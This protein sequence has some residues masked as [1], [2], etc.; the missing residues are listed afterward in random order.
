MTPEASVING[1]LAD[2][3]EFKPTRPEQRSRFLGAETSV[4][5]C[6]L[7]SSFQALQNPRRIADNNALSALPLPMR[8]G[9]SY[10]SP[11]QQLSVVENTG[12]SCTP[13]RGSSL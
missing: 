5:L 7:I 8:Q 12:R 10:P 1:Q 2:P 4:A 13:H 11:C 9:S 3:S 6:S